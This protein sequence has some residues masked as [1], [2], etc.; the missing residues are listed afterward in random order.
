M[1][2]GAKSFV[3]KQQSRKGGSHEESRHYIGSCRLSCHGLP[4]FP[5]RCI[6]RT[7]DWQQQIA[8]ALGKAGTSAGSVY[9]VGL[10]RTDIEATLDGVELKPGFALGGWLAFEKMGHNAMVMGDLVLTEDEVN[11][12]MA[13]L[14]AG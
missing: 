13:K 8:Q 10:P 11:P 5:C 7:G 1:P 14:L 9:R 3:I 12:V 2:A 4:H 6:R